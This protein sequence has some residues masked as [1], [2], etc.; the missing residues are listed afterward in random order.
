[1]LKAWATNILSLAEESSP[2]F[3]FWVYLSENY[4]EFTGS[5]T[6]LDLG[7][8]F[9]DSQMKSCPVTW[10]ASELYLLL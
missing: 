8:A 3:F 10:V 9:K 4:E 6:F 7:S 1:V 2:Q 5:E